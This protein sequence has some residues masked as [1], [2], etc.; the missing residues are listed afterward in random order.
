[1]IKNG[2][3][4][5][6]HS[7]I[8]SLAK[9]LVNYETSKIEFLK[10]IIY[11]ITWAQSNLNQSVGPE[12]LSSPVLVWT[13]L[14]ASAPLKEEGWGLL[15]LTLSVGAIFGAWRC[16][17]QVTH[18]IWQMRRPL[19]PNRQAKGNHFPLDS[20]FYVLFTFQDN[21]SEDTGIIIILIFGKKTVKTNPFY[22]PSTSG[23]VH[24]LV[25]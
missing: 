5:S 25:E 8:R 20:R 6:F 18:W 9:V 13:C 23:L 10:S 12:C 15:S 2:W 7:F 1:M 21:R 4:R 22:W 3:L 24:V 16:S 11:F 19:N 17:R 14:C